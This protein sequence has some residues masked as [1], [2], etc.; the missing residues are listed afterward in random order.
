[1]DAAPGTIWMA[2]QDQRISETV[3]RERGR[4]RNFVRRWVGDESDVEDIVQE[5]FYELV[6]ASRMAQP[7]E[8]VGAW[9]FRVARNRVIDRFR[10]KRPET[11]MQAPLSVSEDDEPVSLEDLLPSPDEGPEAAYARN[12]LLDELEDALDELPEEQRQVFVANEIEGRS[13][14]ELAEATGVNMN[15]LMARKHY[16]V[17]RLRERLQ[18]IYDEL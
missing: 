16:A 17:L 6:A 18:E 2:E 1:M 11:S 5:V 15:T 12:V 13:F 14:R 8:Q 4:L 7:I 3:A 9:L 10:K